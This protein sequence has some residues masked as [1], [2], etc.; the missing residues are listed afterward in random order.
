ML[1][2]RRGSSVDSNR[3]GI[4]RPSRACLRR[5]RPLSCAPRSRG[6]TFRGDLCPRRAGGGAFEEVTEALVVLKGAAGAVVHDIE[7]R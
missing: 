6:S 5:R 2:R 7:C 4:N 1:S 3:I